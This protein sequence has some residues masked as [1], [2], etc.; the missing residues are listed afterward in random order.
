MLTLG[1][2]VC[3]ASNNG[4]HKSRRMSRA[5]FRASSNPPA[6]SSRI[7]KSSPPNRAIVSVMRSFPDMRVAIS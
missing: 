6:G 1:Y 3:E 4:S 7:A 2:T 5:N